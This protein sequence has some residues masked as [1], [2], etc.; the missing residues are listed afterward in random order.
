MH[1]PEPNLPN[2]LPSLDSLL[3]PEKLPPAPVIVSQSAGI[4]NACLS[5]AFR[6]I[7]GHHD[8]P[9]A[10]NGGPAGGTTRPSLRARPDAPV[11]KYGL[12]GSE[13]VST[14]DRA[15]ICAFTL[16]H[17]TTDFAQTLP[18][19]KTVPMDVV[20]HLH[21]FTSLG[22]GQCLVIEVNVLN[23]TLHDIGVASNQSPNGFT[24]QVG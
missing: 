23:R 15:S 9:A 22:V 19:A 5:G 20:P 2:P 24:K 1:R 18:C 21:P 4:H 3:L 6:R 12:S 17:R 8:R 11:H 7:R 10:R 16:N 14:I 13:Y